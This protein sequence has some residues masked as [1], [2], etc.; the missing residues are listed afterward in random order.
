MTRK[1]EI[2]VSRRMGT[3]AFKK[4]INHLLHTRSHM[5][6]RHEFDAGWNSRDHALVMAMLLKRKGAYP[7]IANGKCMYVQGPHLNYSSMGVGQEPDHIGGHSWVV[8]T[9]FGL[10]DVSP[11]L[12]I[13][14]HRFRAAFNG[15]YGRVWLPQGKDRVKVVVCDDPANYERELD[16]AAHLTGQSTAVYM[17][18]QDLEV[19]DSLIENPF[20]F[21]GSDISDEIKKRFGERFYPA[22]ASHLQ[23]F[24][25]GET[26]SLTGLGELEAWST[27]FDK[28]PG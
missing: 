26:D 21:L 3:I 2:D 14:K 7:K 18:L 13:K 19:T 8:D 11:V 12:E 9:K 23:S 5:D 28:F 1:A 17:H 15:I 6:G 24:M 27:V 10:I 22:V 4:E 25:L 16:K 20:K